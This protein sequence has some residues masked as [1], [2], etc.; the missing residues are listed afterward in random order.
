MTSVNDDKVLQLFQSM[1]KDPFY[2]ADA[3]RS[4]EEV[5]LQEATQRI[6]QFNNNEKALSMA[7]D[8][9]ISAVKALLNHANLLKAEEEDYNKEVA[10]FKKIDNALKSGKM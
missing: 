8:D 1:M 2:Q 4:R 6:R 10:R 9:N 7:V 5:V 3:N